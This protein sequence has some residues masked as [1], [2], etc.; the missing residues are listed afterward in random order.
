MQ[1][2]ILK[3]QKLQIS[4]S[5]WFTRIASDY[6]A[7]EKRYRALELEINDVSTR[8]NEVLRSIRPMVRDLVN[9]IR[10]VFEQENNTAIY[11]P[12]LI[13]K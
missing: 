9:D 11:I 3:D 13:P 6:P 1:N 4:C 10:T 8:Q 12:A 7:I 5:K 2:F